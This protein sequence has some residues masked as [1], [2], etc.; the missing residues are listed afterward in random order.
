MSPADLAHAR[1]AAAHRRLATLHL[2]QY[3]A[4]R[5]TPP[6]WGYLDRLRAQEPVVRRELELA[7]AL[8]E[9]EAVA[10]AERAADAHR[11]CPGPPEVLPAGYL[12]D[13]VF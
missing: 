3:L 8:A 2:C 4:G 6:N 9:E 7:R 11:E 1:Y 13:V 5:E 12:D 10:A